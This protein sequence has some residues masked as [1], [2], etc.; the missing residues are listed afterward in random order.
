VVS[1][2]PLVSRAVNVTVLAP[3]LAI[4]AGAAATDDW[5]GSAAPAAA[6]T[7]MVG[8]VE[9][10]ACPPIVAVIV[11]VPAALAVRTAV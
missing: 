3:P 8:A 11:F 9:V 2:V 6:V 7:V 10:T 4:E 1:W 5:P